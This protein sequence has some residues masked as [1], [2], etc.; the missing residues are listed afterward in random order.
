MPRNRSL[1]DRR[2][3]ADNSDIFE[4]FE[5]L[6]KSVDYAK[7]E[8]MARVLIVDDDERFQDEIG[9]LFRSTKHILKS[10]YDGKKGLEALAKFKP[11]IVFLDGDMPALTGDE[12]LYKL[13]NN[14]KYEAY[15]KTPIIGISGSGFRH[16]SLLAENVGKP[17]GSDTIL[18]CID[19]YCK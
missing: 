13:N 2:I 12:F 10:A 6:K 4:S 16:K 1:R 3:L 18:R 8:A 19:E 15:R 7:G 9:K 5:N 11:D 17:V 14:K